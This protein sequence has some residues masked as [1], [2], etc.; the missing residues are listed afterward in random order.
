MMTEEQRNAF[1]ATL[2]NPR[3]AGNDPNGPI[4][5]DGI[6]Q[7]HTLIFYASPMDKMQYGR[8]I[9]EKVKNGDYG[10]IGDY[11]PR[12]QR[13]GIGEP[14]PLL[15]KVKDLTAQVEELKA[16]VEELRKGKS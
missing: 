15:Q 7:E 9:Y 6:F 14:H 3:Y 16:I 5:L 12:I 11:V 2:N 10:P 4:A 1:L 8:D 13:D